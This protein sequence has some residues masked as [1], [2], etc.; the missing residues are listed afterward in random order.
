MLRGLLHALTVKHHRLP[1]AL[2]TRREPLGPT[3]QLVSSPCVPDSV[4]DDGIPS[5]WPTDRLHLHKAV[6]VGWRARHDV[7]ASSEGN[8]TSL[9]CAASAMR[10][11]PPAAVSS[12]ESQYGS[13][14]WS[15]ETWS[16]ARQQCVTCCDLCPASTLPPLAQTVRAAATRISPWPLVVRMREVSQT[17]G[18][19]NAD[20]ESLRT[21]ELERL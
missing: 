19:R 5:P 16:A 3:D 18:D 6:P 15:P 2:M 1:G 7:R 20:H 13:S 8:S 10:C 9:A 12:P 17:R 4:G 21:G 14:F 11:E